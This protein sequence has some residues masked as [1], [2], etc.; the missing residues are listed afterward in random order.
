MLKEMIITD[1]LNMSKMVGHEIESEMKK[2][3][4]E[5][6]MTMKEVIESVYEINYNRGFDLECYFNIDVKIDSKDHDWHN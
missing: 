2:I 6:S 5:Y 3:I 4:S 1:R